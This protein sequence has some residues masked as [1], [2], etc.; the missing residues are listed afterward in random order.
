MISPPC[1]SWLIFSL[2]G[3]RAFLLLIVCEN[4]FL[5][6]RLL[7]EWTKPQE[8][9]SFYSRGCLLFTAF[10]QHINRTVAAGHSVS[11]HSSP[12]ILMAQSTNHGSMNKYCANFSQKQANIY[13]RTLQRCHTLKCYLLRKCVATRKS[14]SH[15]SA[16]LLGP[17]ICHRGS[18]L[19]VV[20]YLCL[21][22]LDGISQRKLETQ[23]WHLLQL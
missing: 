20:L 14:S 11:V 22:K 15:G 7:P 5:K 18:L 23:R 16:F 10:V 6:A 2:F 4:P 3:S 19:A 17:P 12:P 1:G 21:S 13:F 9:A 8:S